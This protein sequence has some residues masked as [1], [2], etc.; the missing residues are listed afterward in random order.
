MKSFTL[1]I[2]YNQ[3]NTYIH[4]LS[5]LCTTPVCKKKE[6]DWRDGI[7][8]SYLVIA[9]FSLLFLEYDLS[10]VRNLFVFVLDDELLCESVGE[11]D[12][13]PDVFKD[14][15]GGSGGG[16][17]IVSFVEWWGWWKFS[18]RFN[19]DCHTVW[20]HPVRPLILRDDKELSN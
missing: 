7:Y 20:G 18:L 13:L 9:F 8:L 2:P 14:I 4:I 3:N 15:G 16:K 19:S 1:Y 12:K 10:Y 6:N 11:F 17:R 5:N